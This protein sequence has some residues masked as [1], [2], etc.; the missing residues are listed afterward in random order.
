[1][2]FLKNTLIVS[3]YLLLMTLFFCGGYAIGKNGAKEEDP[4]SFTPAPETVKEVTADKVESPVY[5]LIIENGVLKINKCIDKEKTVV[6]SEEI[7]ESVFPNEDVEELRKGIKFERL[8]QAQQM[9]ENF[10]S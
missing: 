8:E 2:K 9:F 4:A 5:E 3:S 10:V 7:S 1:M 6:T